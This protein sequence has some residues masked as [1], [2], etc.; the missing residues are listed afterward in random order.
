LWAALVTLRALH[1]KTDPERRPG[2][3]LPVIAAASP[4]LLAF[5]G[6]DLFRWWTLG[7]LNLFVVTLILMRMHSEAGIGFRLSWQ[8]ITMLAAVGLLTGPVGVD[9]PF[10]RGAFARTLV[11]A[12]LPARQEILQRPTDRR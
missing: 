1:A 3:W 5:V 7:V 2:F 11:R 10:P 4:L 12:V 9:R 6:S 8:R